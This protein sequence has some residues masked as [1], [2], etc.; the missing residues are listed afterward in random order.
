[1]LHLLVQT[2]HR[3]IVLLNLGARELVVVFLSAQLLRH[4]IQPLLLEVPAGG[5]LV[6][7]RQVHILRLVSDLSDQLLH[8]DL[9]E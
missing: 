9:G 3:S 1:M 6:I 7:T 4:E 8:S 2:L 5:L